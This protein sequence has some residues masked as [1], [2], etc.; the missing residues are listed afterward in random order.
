MQVEKAKELDPLSPIIATEAGWGLYFARC[1]DE[2]VLHLT[3][4]LTLETRFSVAH[5]ILGLVYQQ[6]GNFVAAIEELKAAIASY[7]GG[8][9]TL[10]I[11][12]LG[13]AYA[14]SGERDCAE[15][16]L[17]ELARLAQ[18]HYVSPY[19]LA[20]VHAGLRNDNEAL[21]ALELAVEERADRLI[22]LNVDPLFDRL[23][24][25]A[26]FKHVLERLGLS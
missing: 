9:F 24:R 25:R 7:V 21:E 22:F 4:T 12:A 2:A 10:A 19:C 13:H 20:V 3:Q 5:F 23:R 11:A 18:R 1:H 26:R 14:L 15:R 8:P 6:T 16:Q 17:A